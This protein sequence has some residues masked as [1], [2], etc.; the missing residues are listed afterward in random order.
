MIADSL[1]PYQREAA[2]RIVNAGSMLLAD[3]PGLG[4]TFTSLG[5]LELSGALTPGSAS[6]VIAPLITC[7]TA[8][9]PTAQ[10]Y[11][12]EVNVIDAFSG[13]RLRR[14]QR[15]K[16]NFREDMPN[17]I[18]TNHDSIGISKEHVSFIPQI[19]TRE[20]VAI[21]ID[22][23]HA[24]LPMTYDAMR[25]A[26]QFWRG[27]NTIN[28]DSVKLRI[29]VS[30]TPDRGKFHYRLGTW[31]FLM[32][33]IYM[34]HKISYQEWV[35]KNFYNYEVTVPVRKKDGSFFETKIQK[36]GHILDRNRWASMDSLKLIR[37]TK[38]EVAKD[39]PAKQY[40]DVDVPFSDKLLKSYMDYTREFMLEDD[41][42]IKNAL[43]YAL[44]AAQ[45]ATCQWKDDGKGQMTPTP[46]GESPKRDWIFEWLRERNLLGEADEAPTCKVVIS[47]Q[48]TRVLYWLKEELA[49]EGAHAEVIS[50]DIPQHQ[51]SSIQQLFQDEHSNLRIVLLS[52]GLGVG[53]DLDMAD[54]LIF[55]D[56]PRNPDIQ[57]QVED[58]IHRV[59]RIHNVTIW[60]LRSRETIDVTIS[61]KNDE[62]FQNTRAML[63]GVRAVDFDRKILERIGVA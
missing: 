7:D 16:D 3:Q 59:S 14:G 51:R 55:I 54:D 9:L 39:L 43:V 22:E 27:L 38:S 63:D 20:F 36:I 5:A 18:V 21:I 6:I 30:G 35:D 4:K 31:R 11:M 2:D 10:S 32:P 52:A 49:K 19:I 57:E 40:V 34:P 60:R 26:T 13:S 46:N 53:I 56:T 62:I 29:A 15:I 8:W 12:P 23:S 42:S 50:G 41:G 24:V 61:A 44:R 45:F 1:K 48:Y 28:N 25:E 47:S 37:R 17:L 33:E 58:R